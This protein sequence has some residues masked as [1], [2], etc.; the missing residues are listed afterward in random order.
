MEYNRGTKIS[1]CSH[2]HLI[3][4]TGR[5]DGKKD[6]LFNKWFWGQWISTCRRLKLDLHFLPHTK[7]NSK[8]VKDF[9]V[10]CET[11]RLQEN[12]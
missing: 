9:N 2:S 8:W 10:E 4:I 12:T 1:L 5:N 3:F 7:I 6:S 11:L